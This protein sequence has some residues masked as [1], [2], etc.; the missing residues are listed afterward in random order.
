MA[1][2]QGRGL[3]KNLVRVSSEKEPSQE[4]VSRETALFIGSRKQRLYKP[5]GRGSGNECTSL[6]GAGSGNASLALRRIPGACWT[7][8]YKERGSLTRNLTTSSGEGSP[9][10]ICGWDMQPLSR[11]EMGL[12][13]LV[14]G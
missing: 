6:A 7:C 10:R 12:L 1:L 5:V 9:A 11:E 4:T 2:S 13:L 8:P 3:G 14:S